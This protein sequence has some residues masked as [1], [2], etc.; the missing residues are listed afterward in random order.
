MMFVLAS[1]VIWSTVGVLKKMFTMCSSSSGSTPK[2]G[3]KQMQTVI[4]QTLEIGDRVMEV[5]PLIGLILLHQLRH[6]RGVEPDGLTGRLDHVLD[7]L[8]ESVAW[9]RA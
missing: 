9:N 4:R 6:P 8:V 2:L 7:I 3:F 5:A 1:L